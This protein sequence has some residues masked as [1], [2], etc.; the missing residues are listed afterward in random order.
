MRPA[1]NLEEAIKKDLNFAAGAELHD[2]ML[3]DVLNAQ[4]KSRKECSAVVWPNL[5]RHIMK[6]PITKL[7]AAAAIIVAVALSISVWNRTT[8]T[9]Y[10]LEQTVEANHTVRSLHVRDFKSGQDEPKEFW[11]QFDDRG[12][13]KSVRAYMP[14]WESPRDGAKL[15]VWQD[16]K[17]KVWF[18]KRNTLVTVRDER[19]AQQMLGLALQVDPRLAMERLYEQ[20]KQGKVKVEIDEPSDSAKPIAVTA[21]FA[22]EDPRPGRRI[23]LLVDQTTRL[24]TAIQIY[25]LKDNEYQKVGVTEIHDYN[26]AIDPGVFTLDDEVPADVMRVDQTTQEVGLAQGELSDDEVAVE[27]ARQ[28]FTAL[29]AED[30]AAAGQLF[31]GVPVEKM[32][33]MFGPIKILRIVSVGP[34]A[35]HPIPETRGLVVP[36][37]IEIQKDGQTSEWKL[38]RLGVRQ[39]YNQPGRWTIFGGI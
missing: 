22:P 4:E 24:I 3:S 21:T 12:Q 34:A 27:V 9:A 15:I 2:R 35:P 37:T 17:A 29:M 25:H 1:D 5:R 23:V 7:A 11:L 16:G 28:F 10:A 36:C 30:Y 14:E 6:S 18:K 19:L 31:E 39:V 38:D 32:R 33:E 8:P 26:Q 20:E 13:V